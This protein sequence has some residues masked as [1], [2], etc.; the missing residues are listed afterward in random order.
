MII[1]AQPGAPPD[2]EKGMRLFKAV[3]AA[4]ELT[5]RKTEGQGYGIRTE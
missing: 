4:G 5:A 3:G 2:R 1:S